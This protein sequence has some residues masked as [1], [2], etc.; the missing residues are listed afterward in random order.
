MSKN[1]AAEERLG[2]LHCIVA[3]TLIK[4][5]DGKPMLNEAGEII[6]YEVD[7]RIISS[8]ITFL[9]NNKVTANPFLDEAMS[10]IEKRL[11]DRV[12]KFRKVDGG[13]AAAR[14]AANE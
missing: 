9:N 6:G 14:A 7:P 11:K 2:Q 10:E 5:L 3:E 8:A 13:K 4:Q 12:T 1:A